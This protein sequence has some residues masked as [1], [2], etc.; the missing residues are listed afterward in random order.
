MRAVII[1]DEQHCIT[2]LKWSLQQYCHDIEV[3]GVANNGET[4]FLLIK[5]T[6]PDLVFLDIEMPILSGI[7][8][9]LKLDEIDFKVIFTTA[10]DKYAV[11]AIK[12]NALDFLLKPIDKD[13]L[14]TSIGKAKKEMNS[15]TKKQVEHLSET[16]KTK[17]VDKIALS[18]G[19]GIQFINLSE[20]VR[21]EADGNYC[22]FILVD[23]R[24][25]LLSKKLGNAEEILIDNASFYRAH[26]SHIINLKYVDRYIR[27]EGGEII[28]CDGTSIS[29]SR[30]KK[31]EFMEFWNKL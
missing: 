21:V 5:E 2:T 8:M 11:K 6:H 24:K 4:G 9:L 13:E 14:V 27:G 18:L 12:L 20:I 1:D 29:L 3:V 23:K 10:Y 28:M 26:K 25:I 17:I 16:H 22:N 30:S 15:I 7:D 19:N 31:E